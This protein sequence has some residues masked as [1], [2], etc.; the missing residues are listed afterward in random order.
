[1]N[2]GILEKYQGRAKE[3]IQKAIATA[4]QE[5]QESYAS[6]LEHSNTFD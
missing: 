6:L 4:L 3:E 1:M 5:T 2:A